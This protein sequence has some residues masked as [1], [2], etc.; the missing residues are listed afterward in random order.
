MKTQ[1]KEFLCPSG[2][3]G[4]AQQNAAA[5]PQSAGITNYKAMG[6]TTRDSLKMVADPT[7]KPPYGVMNPAFGG[8]PLHPDGA[9]FPGNGSRFADFLD[10]LSHTVMTIET[11]DETASRWTVGKEA[12]LVGLPQKSSPTGEKPQ[13][14]YPYFAPPGYDNT[15]GEDSG[16]TRAG[17]RT[18]LSYDFSPTGAE[19]GKY[20]DAGFAKT[21]PSY[22]PSSPHPGVVIAGMGDGSVRAL[23]KRID[24]A[25]LFFLITKNGA[26]PFNLP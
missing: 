4:S 5:Q 24:A 16:V 1:I 9:I 6:A 14:P 20:E 22:G 11:M 8:A 17:V 2:P 18:F 3:R 26:D 10:G 15:W 7:A 19:A 23:S 12:T 13:A 25:N 21:P